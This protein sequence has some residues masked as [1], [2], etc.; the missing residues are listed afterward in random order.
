MRMAADELLVDLARHGLEVEQPLL[1][2]QLRVEN[3]LDEHVAQLLA[4]VRHV[5]PVDRVEQF[6]TLLDQA[7][8][9]RLVR[10]L[11]V[12]RTAVRRAQA[13]H[14]TAKIVNGT[15]RAASRSALRR[16]RTKN[17]RICATCLASSAGTASCSCRRCHRPA[18]LA[19]SCR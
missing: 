10:L 7:D 1:L 19:A 9:Q 14:G 2:G 8:G 17:P 18:M 11:P 4:H 13:G 3:D 12:P 5:E 15:H 16:G 6:G